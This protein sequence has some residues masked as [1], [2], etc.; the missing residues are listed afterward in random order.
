MR[1][2]VLIGGGGHASDVLSVIEARNAVKPE[3]R[4]VGYLSEDDLAGQRLE[5]RG[6]ARLGV[7]EDLDRIDAA[8]VLAIGYPQVRHAVASR[9]DLSSHEAVTL[10]HPHAILNTDVRV[11]TGA[12]VL[13]G[14]VL[15]ANVVVE[16]HAYVGQLCSI[17]HDTVLGTYSSVMPGAVV[18]GDVVVG[19]Q[20]LIGTSATVLQGLQLGSRATLGGSS[21]L[22]KDLPPDVT[23]MGVPARWE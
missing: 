2:V 8:Y 14:C 12:V 22:T 7:P 23:A 10:V 9:I 4:C 16:E 5:R 13:A 17:G 18:S 21:L 11:E 20:V 15:S 19:T 6:L 1:D 3:F